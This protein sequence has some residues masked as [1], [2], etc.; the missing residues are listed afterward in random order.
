MEPPTMTSMIPLGAIL[1]TV[2]GLRLGASEVPVEGGQDA[3]KPAEAAA[4]K[5][6]P[7]LEGRITDEAGRPL[8]GAKVI[9]YGGV[10]TRWKIA[11]AETG[12]DGRYRFDSVQ[13]TL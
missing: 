10:A 1:L 9:L 13:S 8:R 2:V 6:G 7:A 11:E 4:K 12:A 3:Q 5:R